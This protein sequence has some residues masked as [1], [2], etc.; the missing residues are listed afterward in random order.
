M[1][2]KQ[3]MS[4]GK[5]VRVPLLSLG[6]G[7]L[8]YLLKK[9]AEPGVAGTAGAEAGNVLLLGGCA[10]SLLLFLLTGFLF[11]RGMQK[12]EIVR[13]AAPVA[14]YYLAAFLAEQALGLSG[15]EPPEWLYLP[16]RMFRYA[17]EGLRRLGFA[18]TLCA[19]PALL[20]PF[21]YAA[22]GKAQEPEPQ[23]EQEQEQE[24][25]ES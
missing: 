9:L 7:A 23:P 22:F 10:A 11:L 5:R 13:S 1:K 20:C 12:D 6:A 21:F 25:T 14:L 24:K 19:A 3:K 16:V 8:L 18:P 2:S 15:A 17:E 4:V